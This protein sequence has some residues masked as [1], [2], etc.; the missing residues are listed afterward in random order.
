MEPPDRLAMHVSIEVR[1]LPEERLIVSM[2]K[3]KRPYHAKEGCSY[4]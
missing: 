2:E 4:E 3:A 1:I